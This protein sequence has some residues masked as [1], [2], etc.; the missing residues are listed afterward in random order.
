MSVAAG[1]THVKAA[2]ILAFHLHISGISKHTYRSELLKVYAVF[3]CRFARMHI[4]TLMAYAAVQRSTTMEIV[5]SNCRTVAHLQVILAGQIRSIA[6]EHDIHAYGQIRPYGSGRKHRSANVELL[7]YRTYKV[8][9]S[10]MRR[11]AQLF[12]N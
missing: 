4:Q 9:R 10:G 7:P 12:S 5:H 11:F 2:Y 3:L 1:E 6:G 8:Y